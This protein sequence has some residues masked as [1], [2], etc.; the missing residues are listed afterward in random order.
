MLLEV[1]QTR[2]FIGDYRGKGEIVEVSLAAMDCNNMRLPDADM[3]EAKPEDLIKMLLPHMLH[4]DGSL[5]G[6]A[7]EEIPCE[8]HTGDRATAN[9]MGTLNEGIWFVGSPR[10]LAVKLFKKADVNNNYGEMEVKGMGRVLRAM[11]KKGKAEDILTDPGVAVPHQILRVL[12]ANRVFSVTR[13]VEGKPTTNEQNRNQF[14][15]AFLQ[16][17]GVRHPDTQADNVLYNAETQTYTYIDCFS[18]YGGGGLYFPEPESVRAQRE[19]MEMMMMVMGRVRRMM[20]WRMSES[21]DDDEDERERKRERKMKMMDYM[22]DDMKHMIR[23][24]RMLERTAGDEQGRIA[25]V[26]EMMDEIMVEMRGG[27]EQGRM[28]MMVEKME[29]MIYEMRNEMSRNG[30]DSD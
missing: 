3:A 30:D 10:V 26:V 11:V 23:E 14:K 19:A 6:E 16:K 20:M 13:Y 4:T 17:H 5:V 8:L 7:A 9:S 18:P 12:G 21:P 25:R 27:D 22:K 1:P 15:D 2:H 24:I 28:A 29:R